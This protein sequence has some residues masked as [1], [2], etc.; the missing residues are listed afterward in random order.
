MKFLCSNIKNRNWD[1][2]NITKLVSV[3]ILSK[4]ERPALEMHENAFFTI[5]T[6]KSE[7]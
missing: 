4:I 6:L 2:I 3:E 5:I 1:L 7:Y